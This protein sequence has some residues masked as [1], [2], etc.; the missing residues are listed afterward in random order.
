MA[1]SPSLSQRMESHDSTVESL[2]AIIASVIDLGSEVMVFMMAASTP[3]S[4]E[5]VASSRISRCG[6]A[7]RARAME[8]RC[9]CPPERPLPPSPMGR[10][11][12]SGR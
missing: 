2:W 7:Y 6:E 3:M 8:R 10:L 11:M 1:V 12:P 9:N 5:L 4:S